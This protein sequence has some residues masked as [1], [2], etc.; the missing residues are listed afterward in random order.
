MPIDSDTSTVAASTAARA[1]NTALF[2]TKS[3]AAWTVQQLSVLAQQRTNRLLT[4]Y[5]C[6]EEG[7]VTL[8]RPLAKADARIENS[9][10]SSSDGKKASVATTVNAMK[11]LLSTG[12]QQDELSKMRGSKN[13]ETETALDIIVTVGVQTVTD[14]GA[15][16]PTGRQSSEALN[17]ADAVVDIEM[18]MGRQLRVI[19]NSH[20][21]VS[22]AL[23]EVE[24]LSSPR[25]R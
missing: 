25:S 15:A 9:V 18:C 11:R 4:T 21:D 3:K 22:N 20:D 8:Q 6:L 2:S 10:K 7:L 13:R 16:T 5:Y 23:E 14:T 19:S 1:Q 17:F 24:A 12:V